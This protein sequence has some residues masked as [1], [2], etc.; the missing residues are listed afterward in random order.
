M[1]NRQK[2]IISDAASISAWN[3]V[4]DCPSIVA[5]FS[6]GRH[7]VASSSA[8]RSSTAARSSHGQLP[9]SRRASA[10]AAIACCTCSGAGQV[11]VGEHVAVIVRHHGLRGLAGADFAA[12]DDDR[13]VEPLARH[14]LAAAP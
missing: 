9:H 5:A 1:L 8:A 13:D 7:D 14:L 4:F 12:A 2:S 10:A 11:V 6:V 3:A